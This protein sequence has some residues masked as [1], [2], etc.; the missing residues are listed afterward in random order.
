[1]LILRGLVGLVLLVAAIVNVGRVHLQCA[2][3]SSARMRIAQ[4]MLP[5]E[6]GGNM[7]VN[8]KTFVTAELGLSN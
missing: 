4:E 7:V 3:P 5:K 6:T 1:M 2:W 8:K